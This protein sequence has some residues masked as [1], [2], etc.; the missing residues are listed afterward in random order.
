[1]QRKHNKDIVPTAKMLRKNMTKEEEH[2]IRKYIRIFGVFANILITSWNNP[3]VSFADSSLYTREPFLFTYGLS[4]FLTSTAFVDTNAK[5]GIPI[6]R[7]AV[8]LK[9]VL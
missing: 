6:S 1:M 4:F 2:L 5:H 9:T 3:S 7:Y 8:F